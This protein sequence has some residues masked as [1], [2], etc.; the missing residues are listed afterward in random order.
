MILKK[1]VRTPPVLSVIYKFT[2][3]SGILEM[4]RNM[5]V[6]ILVLFVVAGGV[7]VVVTSSCSQRAFEIA[8]KSCVTSFYAELRKNPKQD[9]R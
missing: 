8:G 7:S 2:L 3:E 9:C 6:Y 4:N 5:D 1:T